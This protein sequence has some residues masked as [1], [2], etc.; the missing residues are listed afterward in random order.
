[1]KNRLL[2]T[3]TTALLVT[4]S[5]SFSAFAGDG[6]HRKNVYRDYARVTHVEP[7]YRIVTRRTPQR[8]CDAPR[9]HQPHQP[10]HNSHRRHHRPE[11]VFIGGVIGGAIGHEVTR[12]LNGRSN[13]GAVVA[14]AAIGAGL[15]ASHQHHNNSRHHRRDVISTHHNTHRRQNNHRPHSRPH[16]T[17]TEH[18]QRIKKPDGFI[19]TYRFRGQTFQTHTDHHPGDRIPVRVAISTGR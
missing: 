5:L 3:L 14:G 8:T 16:C 12:S 17:T 7:K 4:S 15:V 18:V 11:A 6:H 1:M 2:S 13:P 10:R 9:H 19:V